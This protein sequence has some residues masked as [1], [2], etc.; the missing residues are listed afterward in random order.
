MRIDKREIVICLFYNN[1]KEEKNRPAC[2]IY[3][4][5]TLAAAAKQIHSLTAGRLLLYYG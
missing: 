1:E 2:G 5:Y 3:L 4:T